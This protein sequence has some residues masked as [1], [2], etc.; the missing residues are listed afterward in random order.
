[1]TLALHRTPYSGHA[2]QRAGP[3]RREGALPKLR[4]AIRRAQEGKAGKSHPV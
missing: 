3:L 2:A 4:E 1:M